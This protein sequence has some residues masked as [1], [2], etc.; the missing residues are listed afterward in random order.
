MRF[1]NIP[2]T[3]AVPLEG[4]T[5]E[6]VFSV[7]AQTNAPIWLDSQ[8]HDEECGRYSIFASEPSIIYRCFGSVGEIYSHGDGW[9]SVGSPFE[10]LTSLFEATME[11][12]W[13]EAG[14]KLGGENIP[15]LGGWIGYLGYN[16]NAHILDKGTYKPDELGFPDCWF[17]YYPAS[18]VFDHIE[19][20]AFIV[21]YFAKDMPIASSTNI[22][23][24]PRPASPYTAIERIQFL[25]SKPKEFLYKQLSA[26]P[27]SKFTEKH[28]QSISKSETNSFVEMFALA[29]ER[30]REANVK[31]VHLSHRFS[32]PFEREP[33]SL[34][35]D[36]RKYFPLPFAAYIRLDSGQAIISS[37]PE[38][39]LSISGRQIIAQPFQGL[40]L[41]DASQ[42]YAKGLLENKADAVKAD[43]MDFCAPDSVKSVVSDKPQKIGNLEYLSAKITGE[44]KNIGNVWEI[45]AKAFPSPA[46]IGAPKDKA[47]SIINE[48][49][50]QGRS[51]YSGIIGYI[52]HG[53]RL[54]FNTAVRTVLYAHNTLSMQIGTDISADVDPQ[55]QYD[56]LIEKMK[57]TLTLPSNNMKNG[58]DKEND[59][60]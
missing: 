40:Y 22:P 17:A 2:N 12:D 53:G 32:F 45:I 54:D 58:T 23:A 14:D 51:I 3:I 33:V 21:T 9:T 56:E 19:N 41:D 35:L 57:R 46:A 16:V 26:L 27:A 25:L 6:D 42:T 31:Q 59:E 39:F 4:I 60:R 47:I 43:F 34:I 10:H 1:K 29:A 38:R 7:L 8:V 11:S 13:F 52:S 44:L 15:F 20:K 36:M 55:L 49:E 18:I 5:V 37:S 24:P 48:L 30:I 50:Q 28:L